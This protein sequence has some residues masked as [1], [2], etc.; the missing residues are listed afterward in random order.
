MQRKT[1]IVDIANKLGITPSAVSKA[2]SG[3]P[4][5]SPETK[6]AVL[7]AVKELNYQPNTLATALK[8]GRSGLIGMI[9]PGIHYSFF[10]TAIKG[11]EELL[12]RQG[13]SVIITQSNDNF[14]HEKK[15]IDGLLRAHVEGVIASMAL[16]TKD[17]SYYK[18]LSGTI[19]L[20]LF[21]RTFEDDHVNSVIIDDFGGAV[22]AVDHL[23][24]M[25]YRRIAHL[26]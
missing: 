22:S 9:V 3:N 14:E 17:T 2:L 25:G 6:N 15:Q 4:R 5:I 7:E 10:A 8:N 21:D 23:V 18:A 19:P 20:V 26:A 24:E 12:S 13:Y 11:A 16:E 1:T